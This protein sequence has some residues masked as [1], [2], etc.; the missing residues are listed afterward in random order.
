MAQDNK[1]PSKKN[2]SGML[3]K[4]G[5]YNPLPTK[6]GAPPNRSAGSYTQLHAPTSLAESTQQC[7]IPS[8]FHPVARWLCR[9]RLFAW[10]RLFN[11]LLSLP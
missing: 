2:G 5:E 3:I 10:Q 8:L 4:H 1:T 7:V 11:D 9:K 6:A